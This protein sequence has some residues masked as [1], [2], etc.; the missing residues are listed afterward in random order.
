MS[1]LVGAGLAL[2]T[3]IFSSVSGLGR[4]RAFFPAVLVVIASYY[5]LFAVISG[6]GAL[7]MELAATAAFILA[8]VIGFRTNLWIVAVALAVHGLFDLGRGELIDN[9]GVPHWWPA[10]CLGFD[11]VAGAY[12]ALLLATKRLRAK[13]HPGFGALIRPEVD[14]ELGAA[15]TARDPAVS[16]HH[17][18]RAHVLGQASTIEHVR[19]HVH[20]LVWSLR[21]RKPSEVVGQAVRIAGAAALTTIGLIPHGNTGGSNVSPFRP[22]PVPEDLAAMIAKAS[23]R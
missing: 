7:G 12:L 10:F 17:L 19:V 16:F 5:D 6:S 15:R 1:Y 4:D 21:H 8:A 20:M 18:E 13:S 23:H 11:I 9:S 22:M 3:G 14:A 2:G